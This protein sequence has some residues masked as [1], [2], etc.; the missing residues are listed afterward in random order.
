[1]GKEVRGG[2]ETAE[3]KL[4]VLPEGH[5]QENKTKWDFLKISHPPNGL[6][7]GKW[8]NTK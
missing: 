8:Q 1:M 2:E 5:G 3:K 6:C 4:I 7:L